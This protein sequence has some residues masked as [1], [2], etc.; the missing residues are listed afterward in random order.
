MKRLAPDEQR[1]ILDAILPDYRPVSEAAP[2]STE[3]EYKAIDEY[4][5][6]WIVP[7][8]H[9]RRWS[10]DARG[11]TTVHVGPSRK[12]YSYKQAKAAMSDAGTTTKSK[13]FDEPAQDDFVF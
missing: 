13:L 7:N 1:A 2:G 10:T 8:P 5:N 4:G 11:Y 12:V 6:V 9:Q 3:P